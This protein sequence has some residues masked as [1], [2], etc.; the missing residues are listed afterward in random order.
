MS[1]G[2]ASARLGCFE[3]VEAFGA[4]LLAGRAVGA[5]AGGAA[6]CAAAPLISPNRATVTKQMRNM[7]SAGVDRDLEMFG[8]N[9]KHLLERA[10]D[11]RKVQASAVYAQVLA[12]FR[13]SYFSTNPFCARYRGQRDEG[14]VARC[15]R[16]GSV[17]SRLFVSIVRTPSRS[18]GLL[19]ASA[20]F[21]GNAAA[22]SMR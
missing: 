11:N 5:F 16:A 8:M 20:G 10:G 7:K 3:A 6:V 15:R 4:A 21:A 13:P 18:T 19:A 22:S 2:P 14:D 1:H 17:L 9:P 12:R